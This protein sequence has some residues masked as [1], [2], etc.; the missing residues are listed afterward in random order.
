MAITQQTRQ[1][2]LFAAED[3]R[4]IYTAFTQVNFSAYDFATIRSAMVDY[5]KLNYPEDFNDWIESSEFVAIIDLL[6]YLGQSLAFRMDLNTRENFMDTATR[7]ESVFR[8]ARMLSYQPRRCYPAN[9]LLKITTVV[10]NQ[11]IYDSYGK[12]LQNLPIIWNDQNNPDWFEQFILVINATLNSTNVFGNPVKSGSINGIHTELYSINNLSIPTSSIPFTATVS[13]NTIDF[14][15]ANVDFNP[16]VTD[17][18]VSSGNFYELAPDPLN[19]WNILY[20]ND[21]NGYGSNDTGFFFYFKQGTLGF[22]DYQCDIEVANRV[23]DIDANNVNETDVWVQTIDTAG[24]PTTK[25]NKV[26]SVN[27]FNIIYNSIEKDQRDIFTVLTRDSNNTDQI[28]IRFA[29]GKFG[30]I[31]SGIIRVWYRTS[32]NLTY[33]VRPTDIENKVFAFNYVD[34]LN[35]VWPVSFTT[36]LQYTVKNAQSNE[37]N[38]RIARNAPQVYYTQDRMVNGEDYNLFPLQNGQALKVKA[39]NRFYSGQSR[40]L[41]VVDPTGNYSNLN[42]FGTDGILYSEDDLNLREI[43]YNPGVSST[44]IVNT[45]IQPLVNG[46]LNSQTQAMELKNFYYYNFPTVQIPSGYTW[47][48]YTSLTKSCTGAIMQGVK[49]VPIG[50]AA[51]SSNALS[52]LV[53]GAL[54]T[55]S[56]SKKASIIGVIENGT[57]NDQTGQLTNGS[58]AVTLSGLINTGDN[59]VSVIP[60][61]RTTFTTEEVSN[62]A[63]ALNTRQSF[64]I[65]YDTEAMGW[66]IINS[67]NLSTT[68]TFS[69][70]YAGNNANLNLDSSWL[71]KV[72]WTGT[73]WKVYSRSLRYIFESVKQ[74]RFYVN[75]TYKIFDANTNTAQID[76]INVLG[77]NAT[78]A[79]TPVQT[80]SPLLTAGQYSFSVTSSEGIEIR[81]VAIG[82]GLAVNSVVTS[83]NNN[84]IEVDQPLANSGANVPITF[85]PAPSLGLDYLWQITGQQIYP[86][87]YADPRAVRL[88]MWEGL[89]YGVPDNPNEYNEIVDPQIIPSRMLF[90]KLVSNSTG[91]EYWDPYDLN[92]NRIYANPAM[93][94]PANDP[95]WLQNE[96]AYIVST[97]TFYQ[98]QAGYLLDVS[99]Q[100]KMRIG[101]K[102]VSYLWKHY[103]SSQ[104]RINPAISNLI[105]MYVL[106]T[107]YDTDLRNWIATNGSPAIKPLPPTSGELNSQFDSLTQYKMMSDQLIW[108]PVKYKVIFGSQSEPEYQVRFKVVKTLG[109]TVTD[110]EVKSLVIQ[111]VNN[112][113]ALSNWDFGESFF[114]TELAAY[115]HQQLATIVASV[116]IT[117]LNAQAKFGDLFEIQCAADEIFI[118]SARVTDVQIVPALTESVLGITNG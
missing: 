20:R 60:A 84:V 98:W 73:G 14:E 36:N 4:V 82:A 93:L 61:F 47:K 23:I 62:I 21:G 57:G 92:I 72:L 81:Q 74:N 16:G 10:A 80:T 108:H 41:D 12:N 1:S 45:Q 28:S 71:V 86:D 111:T 90:W 95:S 37:S 78:P 2:Q 65:R 22:A 6:A 30:N 113:F 110:N 19:S 52:Y 15:L 101:R 115:I 27:G 69:L 118:S 103:A 99:S 117:P 66:K 76:Y 48:N 83:I 112:Y 3:W 33:Q 67:A 53:Q 25:W 17:N 105:D 96:V 89:N 102:N 97:S 50:S 32:N 29:D 26:P 106:T 94:P 77:V 88:T 39:V 104:Q 116:V 51:S 56:S 87:G 31:P 55:F 44:S 46:S 68:S 7:R 18:I 58:G 42:V 107:A 70:E 43:V 79:I 85:Y 13:G 54:V 35:N 75:N 63:A 24:I 34:G 40:Y 59:P 100:Y 49:A 8:L 5:I 91:Y 9:G 109:T 11:P 38:T 64:G 114:F